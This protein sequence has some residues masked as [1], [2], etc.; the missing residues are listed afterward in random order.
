M[1]IV[2]PGRSLIYDSAVVIHKEESKF[3]L[4]R[5]SEFNLHKLWKITI[6]IMLFL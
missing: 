1:E 3:T 5:A 2:K 6:L 4:G